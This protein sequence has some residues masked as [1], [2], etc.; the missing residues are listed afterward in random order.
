MSIPNK[1][2]SIS[3]LSNSSG[4]LFVSRPGIYTFTRK[5]VK[6]HLKKFLGVF[7]GFYSEGCTGIYRARPVRPDKDGEQKWQKP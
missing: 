1:K 5:H 2:S 6:M 3:A 4:Y 7:W